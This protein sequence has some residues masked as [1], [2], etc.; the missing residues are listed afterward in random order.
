LKCYADEAG[1]EM[2]LDVPSVLAQKLETGKLDL[3][4]IPSIEYLRHNDSYKL[5]PGISIA[6]RGPVDTVLLVTQVPLGQIKTLALDDRSR[7]SATLLRLLYNKDFSKDVRFCQSAPNPAQMLENNDA[8]LIIGDQALK[9]DIPS[10][11]ITVF[12]LS[13]EW[14]KRTGMTFVHAVI[15]IAPGVKIDHKVMDVIQKAK[16]D[17]LANLDEIARKQGELLGIEVDICKNY[18]SEKILYNLDKEEMDGL[19]H[20]QKLCSVENLLPAI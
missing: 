9:L 15:A 14:F 6:S 12:D 16:S 10:R 5:L 11:E 4:M 1:L 3:A 19:L 17:G 8:A 18:L 13:E 20:F 2:V 7:T